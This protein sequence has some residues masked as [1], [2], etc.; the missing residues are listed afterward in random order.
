M[1]TLFFALFSSEP[2]KIKVDDFLQNVTSFDFSK[3][4]TYPTEEKYFLQQVQPDFAIYLPKTYQ[5]GQPVSPDTQCFAITNGEEGRRYF[6]H[7]LFNQ[8]FEEEGW[9]FVKSDGE[10]VDFSGLVSG[11][12]K[13]FVGFGA[14]ATLFSGVPQPRQYENCLAGSLYYLRLQ[15]AST[16]FDSRFEM[17]VRSSQARST[18]E[19]LE[20]V[21]TWC[22]NFSS[23]QQRTDSESSFCIPTPG[24]SATASED[25]SFKIIMMNPR[26]KCDAVLLANLLK[27]CDLSYTKNE[28]FA[29][30]IGINGA[31]LSR[32]K[33]PKKYGLYDTSPT[34][35]KVWDWFVQTELT[36]IVRGT[37]AS[38]QSLREALQF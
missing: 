11:D 6:F 35:R 24:R 7:V 31:E 20:R 32:L 3:C 30:L 2:A 8:G 16:D 14:Y 13:T 1:F 25:P 37:G 22:P 33:H 28:E 36:E 10:A 5:F 15:P 9:H 17:L 12:G 19:Y 27:V 38:E 29:T 23:M 21:A 4:A 26:F 18:L 34:V